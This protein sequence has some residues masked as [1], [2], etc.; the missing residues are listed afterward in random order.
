MDSNC[1]K[2][3]MYA[4]GANNNYVYETEENTIKV[5]ENNMYAKNQESY[6]LASPSANYIGFVCVINSWS[7]LHLDNSKCKSIK[8][9][10]ISPIVSLRSNFIPEVVN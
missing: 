2:G 3:Y 9:Y 1:S 10:G 7:S 4:V 5:D 6:W 8:S